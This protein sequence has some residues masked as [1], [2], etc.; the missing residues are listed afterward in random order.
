MLIYSIRS[1]GCEFVEKYP[2][3]AVR[4]KKTGSWIVK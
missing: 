1:R 4:L 3:E 2:Q